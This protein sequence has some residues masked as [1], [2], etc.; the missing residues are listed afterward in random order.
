MNIYVGN[1][2][3]EVTEEDLKQAFEDFGQVASVNIIKDRYS[4]E[5]RG[6]GFVEMPAKAESQSAIEGLNGKE[7]KGQMLKVSEARARSEGRRGGGRRGG[8]QPFY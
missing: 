3:N 4:G 6:F 8:G 1:L 7:L 5:S 2:S